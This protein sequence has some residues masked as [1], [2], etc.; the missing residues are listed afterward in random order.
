[1]RLPFLFAMDGNCYTLP[2]Q[3][4][5]QYQGYRLCP[6][7]VSIISG[8]DNYLGITA[9]ITVGM[10]LLKFQFDFLTDLTGSS[11]FI[12][13]ALLPLLA[14]KG[15]CDRQ[16]MIVVLVCFS[17]AYLAAYLFR[18][19]LKRGHD[20]RFDEMR[21]KFGAFLGFWIFQMLWAWCCTFP[22]IWAAS[23]SVQPPLQASDWAGLAMFLYGL[24]CEVWGDLSKDAFRDK[25]ENRNQVLCSGIWSWSRHPNFFGEIA[26]M[27]G[28]LLIAAATA[29]NPFTGSY[30]GWASLLSPL[31]TMAIML[32]ASG[33]PTAEGSNQTRYLRD[34]VVKAAYLK[35]RATTSPLIPMPPQL[36]GALPHIIKRIFFFEWDMYAMDWDAPMIDVPKP[37]QT[38]A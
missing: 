15:Y 7:Q 29:Y 24:I 16:V 26:M 32:F 1:M 30:T 36:Y 20:A 38:P 25:K 4:Q 2:L 13:I 14:N 35:Y 22:V 17:K 12:V 18:R 21:S 33:M 9:I 34:P 6:N 37:A 10:N 23:S 11:N 19:V 3:Q 31:F 8:D 27:W 5:Q 28:L